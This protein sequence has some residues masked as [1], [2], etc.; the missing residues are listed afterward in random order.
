[1]AS[2]NPDLA[3][4]QVLYGWYTNLTHEV[5]LLFRYPLTLNGKTGT[6]KKV[7]RA[8]VSGRMNKHPTNDLEFYFYRPALSSTNLLATNNIY[9]L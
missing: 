3:T 1:M 2:L 6:G 8:M 9:A 5:R 7:F 4:N